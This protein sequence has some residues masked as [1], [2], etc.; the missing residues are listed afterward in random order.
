M[1]DTWRL[2]VDRLK[3]ASDPAQPEIS[4]DRLAVLMPPIPLKNVENIQLEGQALIDLVA[5]RRAE[6][7]NYIVSLMTYIHDMLDALG[8]NSVSNSC[9]YNR[10]K[11]DGG[12]L[13]TYISANAAYYCLYMSSSKNLDYVEGANLRGSVSWHTLSVQSLSMQ[14]AK[15]FAKALEKEAHDISEIAK[16]LL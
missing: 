15:P 16:K 9:V 6:Y 14:L 7:F 3:P 8:V 4:E 11:D 10:L 13:V 5:A 1:E 12:V 2:L